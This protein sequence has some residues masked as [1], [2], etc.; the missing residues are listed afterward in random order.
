MQN[1]K[2]FAAPRESV[3]A[4][5]A[6]SARRLTTRELSGIA[7]A[8]GIVALAAAALGRASWMLLAACYLGWCFAGWGILFRSAAAQRRPAWRAL[9]FTIV[10][11][12]TCVFAALVIGVFFWALGPSWVL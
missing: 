4:V 1:V 7:A 8:S 5:L 3:Y 12:A 6:S 10:A 2:P 11:S 9:Q